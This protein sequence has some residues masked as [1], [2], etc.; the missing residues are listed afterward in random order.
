MIR[1]RY[2]LSGVLGFGISVAGEML[3]GKAW[4]TPGVQFYQSFFGGFLVGSGVG[5]IFIA[6]ERNHN[7]RKHH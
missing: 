5:I 2:V 3:V 1:M 7:A 4:S 6:I